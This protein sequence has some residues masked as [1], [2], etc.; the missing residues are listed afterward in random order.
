[1]PGN[2]N[3]KEFTER[4]GAKE[5][6]KLKARREKGGGVWFGLG[7]LGSIGWSVAVPT[8]VGIAFGIWLDNRLPGRI[9]WTLTFLFF[10]LIIG[11][12]NAYYWVRRELKMIEEG[13][14]YE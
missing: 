6:R 10:G 1:M 4:V 9:S 13:Q 12:L 11:C 8:M 3:R 5:A 7:M 2:E 14:D